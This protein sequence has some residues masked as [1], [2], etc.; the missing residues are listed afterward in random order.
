MLSTQINDQYYMSFNPHQYSA[1]HHDGA[2]ELKGRTPANKLQRGKVTKHDTEIQLANHVT[3]HNID[4]LKEMTHTQQSPATS[5]K[6]KL[7][8]SKILAKP[9]V[10]AKIKKSKTVLKGVGAKPKTATNFVAKSIAPKATPQT[11]L[12]S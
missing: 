6:T 5:A 4:K 12:L 8:N 10:I 11:K 9:T 2:R 1:E 3:Q 7:T